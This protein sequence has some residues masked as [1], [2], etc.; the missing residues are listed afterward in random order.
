MLVA[1]MAVLF[2]VTVVWAAEKTYQVTG[3]VTELTDSMLVVDKKGEM[4][5][6]ART[7]DTKVKG[8]LKVGEKVTVKYTMTATQIEVKGDK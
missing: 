3:P 1:A 2:A 5:Q 8:D 7:A 6:I 4:H